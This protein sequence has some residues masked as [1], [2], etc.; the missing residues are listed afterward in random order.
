MP[1]A[2]RSLDAPAEV[3]RTALVAPASL[4]LREKNA[5][6]LIRLHARRTKRHAV[7]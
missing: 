3:A 7:K 1:I 4:R 5:V 6:P 2:T